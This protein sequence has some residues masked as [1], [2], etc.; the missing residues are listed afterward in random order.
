MGSFGILSFGQSYNGY[1]RTFSVRSRDYLI[2]PFW[3]YVSTWRGGRV[4]YEVHE[5]GHFLEQV[6]TFL[7]IKHPSNFT[8]MWML[9]AHWDAVHS[10]YWRLRRKVSFLGVGGASIIIILHIICINI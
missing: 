9:V 2:A 8:G 5:S 3:N 6:T 4:I 10:V 1:S 7:Q